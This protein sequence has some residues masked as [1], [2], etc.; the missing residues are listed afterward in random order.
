LGA[1]PLLFNEKAVAH[2]DGTS[3][4][5]GRKMDVKKADWGG[6]R[7]LGRHELVFFGVWARVSKLKGKFWYPLRKDLHHAPKTKHFEF[8]KNLGVLLEGVLRELSEGGYWGGKK[9]GEKTFQLKLRQVHQTALDKS[10][11]VALRVC[12]IKGT[13]V[14]TGGTGFV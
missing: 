11:L 4:K 6:E 8:T 13:K 12:R 14:P 3:K 7:K 2:E 9:G 1:V 10:L 5:K